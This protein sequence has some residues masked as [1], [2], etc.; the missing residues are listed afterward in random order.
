MIAV[1]KAKMASIATTIRT[2]TPRSGGT[3]VAPLVVAAAVAIMLAGISSIA[4]PGRDTI[5][6]SVP[7]DATSYVHGLASHAWLID[8]ARVAAMRPHE[9]AIIGFSNDDGSES[10]VTVVRFIPSPFGAPSAEEREVLDGLGARTSDGRLFSYGDPKALDR[11]DTRTD[12]SLRDDQTARH[13]L[14]VLRSAF[15]VQALIAG[16]DLAFPLSIDASERI[17][18]GASMRNDGFI[19]V[20][21]D[22]DSFSSSGMLGY[23]TGTAE[24]SVSSIFVPPNA[25]LT[26]IPD[27]GE[28]TDPVSFA[29]SAIDDARE[30][31]DVPRSSLLTDASN[32]LAELM[33]G[34]AISL[35]DASSDT[36]PVVIWPNADDHA[37]ITDAVSVY[38][39]ASIPDR[40]PLTLPDGS[41]TT[42]LIFTEDPVF[43]P[44]GPR[45]VRLAERFRTF[46]GTDLFLM[47]TDDRVILAGS[48]DGIRAGIDATATPMSTCSSALH[49]PS[50]LINDLLRY[51][52]VSPRFD[53]VIG[54][55]D[56]RHLILSRSQGA[57][58][59]LRFCG[60]R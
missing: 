12:G 13:A 55:T 32:D 3:A 22:A 16:P 2:T 56:A 31:A 53:A 18:I 60:Y 23:R 6:G 40:R 47:T 42:E 27:S 11:F 43:E 34:A 21:A 54:H 57:N 25:S 4:L 24:A 52:G 10:V 49:T 20:L 37:A 29:L 19:G 30:Q 44:A 46:S 17:A 50:L 45:T 9:F 41:W 14:D 39:A 36:V 35:I 28:H 5:M 26:L 38:L 33:E 48:T 51:G 1:I 58:E 8:D 59:R 15:G 7:S